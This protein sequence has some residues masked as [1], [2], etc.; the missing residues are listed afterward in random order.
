MKDA[1]KK[2]KEKR[3]RMKSLKSHVK[4]IAREVQVK[5]VDP[6]IS[7]LR[8]YPP[9]KDRTTLTKWKSD[10]Q[11]RYMMWLW[12]NR[13]ANL[14][15]ER[16]GDFGR[17]WK[18][19]TK[20]LSRGTGISIAI[21]NPSPAAPYIVGA[22]GI[23]EAASTIKAYEKPIQPFHKDTGWK[24]AHSRIKPVVKEAEKF[25]QDEVSDWM[26]ETLDFSDIN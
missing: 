15:H 25:F 19:E 6:L 7:D 1:I 10:R 14:P 23:G 9:D 22:V 16:T 4:G 3:N 12:K 18:G 20:A 11:R 2:L 8:K 13:K 17:G 21:E 26:D 5:Y 24:P